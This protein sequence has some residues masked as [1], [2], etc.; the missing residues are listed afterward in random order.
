MAEARYLVGPD[1]LRVEAIR[2]GEADLVY[3][4]VRHPQAQAGQSFFLVT[5]REGLVAYCRDVEEVAEFVDLA[6]LSRPGD[7][8]E[9]AG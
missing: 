8:A 6:D 3:A 1:G 9:E 7:A 5:R 2:L 4:R